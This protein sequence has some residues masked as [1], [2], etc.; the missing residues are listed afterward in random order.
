MRGY[1]AVSRKDPQA[2]GN[3]GYHLPSPSDAIAGW[4]VRIDLGKFVG[5]FDIVA[6]QVVRPAAN[7]S[8]GL[9]LYRAQSSDSIWA[10]VAP[11]GAELD[12]Q[13]QHMTRTSPHVFGP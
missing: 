3:R 9:G 7:P 10:D 11:T 13:N 2:K 1:D 12:R 8:A 5:D 4:K 6:G